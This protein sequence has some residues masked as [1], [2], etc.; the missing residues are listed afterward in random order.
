MTHL[1][2]LQFIRGLLNKMI[3]TFRGFCLLNIMSDSLIHNLSKPLLQHALISIL[4]FRSDQ[5]SRIIKY[6]KKVHDFHQII[7]N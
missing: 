1:N 5:N 2:S 7:L 4:L 6:D 3:S